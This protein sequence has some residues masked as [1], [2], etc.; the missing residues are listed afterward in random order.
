MRREKQG[1]NLYK[2]TYVLV[3]KQKYLK[4]NSNCYLWIWKKL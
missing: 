3:S 1:I 4:F 2:N